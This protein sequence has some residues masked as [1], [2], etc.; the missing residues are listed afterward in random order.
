[1]PWQKPCLAHHREV[2]MDDENDQVE[3]QPA[4]LPEKPYPE[5]QGMMSMKIPEMKTSK[6]SSDGQRPP[7]L[8]EEC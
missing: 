8:G 5:V 1:M 7:K 4:E 2:N 3:P 6:Q